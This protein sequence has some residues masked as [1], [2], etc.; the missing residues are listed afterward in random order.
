MK[1]EKMYLIISEGGGGQG[2]VHVSVCV[3]SVCYQGFQILLSHLCTHPP[4]LTCTLTSCIA[5]RVRN[6]QLQLRV[7]GVVFY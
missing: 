7:T 2:Q 3:Y 6:A 4:R 1:L 5:R